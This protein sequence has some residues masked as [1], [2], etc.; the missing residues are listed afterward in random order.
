MNEIFGR[1]R[2]LITTTRRPWPTIVVWLWAPNA[3]QFLGRA[4]R[5]RPVINGWPNFASPLTFHVGL[6][7]Q[8]QLESTSMWFKVE[9]IHVKRRVTW[10]VTGQ[11]GAADGQLLK[12][13]NFFV[14]CPIKMNQNLVDWLFS[15]LLI[16]I[17][18]T[19]IGHIAEPLQRKYGPYLDHSR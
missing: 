9:E 6:S 7:R 3:L 12:F 16:E 8:M 14:Y 19:T 11:C 1:K 4:P 10:L 17:C 18:F 15:W 13:C 5:L 2:I